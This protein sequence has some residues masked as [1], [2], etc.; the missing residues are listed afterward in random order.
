[1][2]DISLINHL[3]SMAPA[4]QN[5]PVK[6]LAEGFSEAL[7]TAVGQVNE[8]Q[9]IADQAVEKVQ[10]GESRNLHEVMIAL[11]KADIS[12]RMLVQVRNKVVEAYQEIMRMQV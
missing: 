12:L 4:R 6:Q 10:T 3:N 8:R 9:M 11:E 7:Q 2:K 5:S 1:M